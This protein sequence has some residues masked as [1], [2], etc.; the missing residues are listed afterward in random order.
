MYN[1]SIKVKRIRYYVSKCHLY[2]YFLIYQNLLISGKKMLMSAELW[3]YF[4]NLLLVRYNCTK[5]HHYGIWVTHFR[6]GDF[7]ATFIREQLWK[8]PSRTGL[9]CLTALNAVDSKEKNYS[10]VPIHVLLN[11]LNLHGFIH[12]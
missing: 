12:F 6:E 9:N 8:C 3:I 7:L 2:L 5:F 4:F 11:F 1:N 10:Y